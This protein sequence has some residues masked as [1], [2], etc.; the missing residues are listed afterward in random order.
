LLSHTAFAFAGLLTTELDKNDFNHIQ[1]GLNKIPRLMQGLSKKETIEEKL[2]HTDY[3]NK[4]QLQVFDNNGQLLLHTAKTDLLPLASQP[5]GFSDKVINDRLWRVFVI[6]NLYGNLKIVV[7]EKY[8]I[9]TALVGRIMQDDIYIMLLIYPLSGLLIWLIIGKGLGSIRS[10]ANE[11]SHRAPTHLEPVAIE[12]V[13]V[14]IKP[15]VNELNQLFQ[16]LQEAFQ[17]EKRFAGDAA[18]ELRTPLAAL[19]TQSQVALKTTDITEQ[20]KFL[21][22]AVVGVDRCTHVVQQLL[23]LSRLAPEGAGLEDTK[24][25]DLSKLAAEIIAQI[26]HVALEKDLDIA[27]I[28]EKPAL[29]IGNPT[30]IGILIRNLVDNAIRYTQEKGSIEVLVE[31]KPKGTLLSVVDNGPGIPQEFHGR[32]FERFFRILGH[33][34]PGSGLGLAIVQQIAKLHNA[35]ISMGTPDLGQGLKIEVFFPK[36]RA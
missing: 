28:A 11:V 3:E 10:V 16:R 29:I 7:A 27:L 33:K 23:I 8:D 13:P 1:I 21:Q 6:K 24:T 5:I 31:E 19:K 25:F 18:H 17:R 12:K 2:L 14:E 30:A 32:V 20:R 4:Y 26:C 15:L 35:E 34:S 9:R 22:N 36:K